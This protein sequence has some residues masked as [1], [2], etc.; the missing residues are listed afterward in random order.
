MGRHLWLVYRQIRHWLDGQYNRARK[1]PRRIMPKPARGF[2]IIELLII[3]AILGVLFFVVL[4]NVPQQTHQSGNVQRKADVNTLL[5]A[6]H[7]YRDA[8]N[9]NL[10]EGITN[11][12]KK[13]ASTQASD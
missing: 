10:P 1:R 9:G 4:A 8:H 2:T 7:M 3:I 5:G 11:E 6:V 12:P 13:I